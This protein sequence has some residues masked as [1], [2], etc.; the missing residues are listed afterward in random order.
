MKPRTTIFQR[1]LAVLSTRPAAYAL[2]TIFPYVLILGSSVLIGRLIVHFNPPPKDWDPTTLWRSMASGERLLVALAIV[3]SAVVPS[4]MVTRGV[5]RMIL[6]HERGD[7]PSLLRTLV[8]MLRFLPVA[9]FYFV[10]W[11]IPAF[12]GS[13]F[14]V[15]PGLAIMSK[16]AFIIPAST[17]A[18]LGP[19]AAIRQGLLLIKPLFG[20]VLAMYGCYAAFGFILQVTVAMLLDDGDASLG[21]TGVVACLAFLVL[22]F[23]PA[24]ACLNIM[25]TLFYCEARDLPTLVIPNPEQHDIDRSTSAG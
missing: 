22:L 8:D 18:R 10:L 12:V 24:I 23:V 7:A 4:Y 2:V 5:C 9:I 11:G 21:L 15:I 6:D 3:A 13:L 1:A 16:C 14:F 17:D 19:L 25:I 20:R